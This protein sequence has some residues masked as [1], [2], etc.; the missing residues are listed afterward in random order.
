VLQFALE[1]PAHELSYG[2]PATRQK[3]ENDETSHIKPADQDQREIDGR[4][5]TV[6]VG[7]MDR[8]YGGAYAI[9][10]SGSGSRS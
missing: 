6:E 8:R 3:I 10:A 5:G 1:D 4:R 7:C 2:L 9:V